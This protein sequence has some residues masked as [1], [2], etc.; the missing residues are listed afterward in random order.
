MID[1]IGQGG[2]LAREAIE[3][4]LRARS[5][6]AQRIEAQVS[7]NFTIDP[8]S[9]LAGGIDSPSK[10]TGGLEAAPADPSTFGRALVDGLREA[11]AGALRLDELPLDMV[12]GQ[13]TDFHQ[14]AAQIKQ[15]ELTFKFAMEVRNKL[16][17]AYR[18]T[19]RMSV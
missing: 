15:S 5:D 6:A 8:A 11:N 1:R 7:Q 17:D 14:L 4:A 18:E 10:L 3:A 13:I 16:I 9:K 2:Q 19:M 12:T